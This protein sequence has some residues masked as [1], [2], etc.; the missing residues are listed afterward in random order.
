MTFISLGYG[1]TEVSLSMFHVSFLVE[2]LNKV[3]VAVVWFIELIMGELE[4][5]CLPLLRSDDPGAVHWS[6][7]FS[8][9]S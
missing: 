1:S 2:N 9:M 4:I 8:G 5:D 6:S 7:P 3:E